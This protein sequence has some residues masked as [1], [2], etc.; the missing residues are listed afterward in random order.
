MVNTI[1]NTKDCPSLW[2]NMAIQTIMK[3]TGSK[4]QSGN[5]GGVFLVPVANLIFEKLLK[6]RISPHLE[7]NITKFQTGGVKGKRVVDNLIIL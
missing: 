4:R 5:Y 1:K 6:N 3:T 2:D 7:Q